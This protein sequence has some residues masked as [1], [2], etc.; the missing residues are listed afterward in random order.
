MVVVVVHDGRC[1]VCVV[2]LH[3]VVIGH[4]VQQVVVIVVDVVL[5]TIVV[6]DHNSCCGVEIVVSVVHV[7]RLQF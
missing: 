1:C 5:Q 6:S 4:V 3:V 2:R 7:G